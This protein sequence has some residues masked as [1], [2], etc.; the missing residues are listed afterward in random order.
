MRRMSW[1]DFGRSCNAPLRMG[2]GKGGGRERSEGL[3]KDRLCGVVVVVVVQRPACLLPMGGDAYTVAAK[4]ARRTGNRRV[5]GGTWAVFS[6]MASG[7]KRVSW[8]LTRARPRVAVSEKRRRRRR[9]KRRGEGERGGGRSS[10]CAM[11]V[12]QCGVNG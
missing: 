10:S 3:R 6:A 11:W 8:W 12:A 4:N 1:A 2:R 5:G 9:R 7:C